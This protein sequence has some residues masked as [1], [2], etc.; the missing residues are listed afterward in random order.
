MHPQ[1]S[2]I[3][4]LPLMFAATLAWAAPAAQADTPA[5]APAMRERDVVHTPVPIVQPGRLELATPSGTVQVPI[6]V[7]RDWT[8]PQPGITRAV[9]VI[10]GW[11]RRDLTSGEYAAR[12]AGPSARD[13]LLITPQFLTAKDIAAHRLP[14][15]M[16]RWR[17]DDWPRARL[18][19]GPV[20][21]SSFEIVDEIF[22]RLAN[23][24]LF[25]N[26][27]MIVLAGHSAGGQYVQRYAALGR[28]EAD[29]G[30]API[31]LRYV[32]ANPATYLYFTDVRPGS[33]GA[34]APF[35]AK[36]CPRFE[37]WNY[38]LGS[39]VPPYAGAPATAEAVQARYLKR[40]VVYLLGTADNSP[41]EDAVGHNCEADAQG[42]TRYARGLA[43]DAYIHMLDPNTHQHVL[44]A[45]GIAHSS[46]RM[47]ASACGM[48]ALFD[49]PGCNEAVPERQ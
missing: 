26:L 32:V 30:S 7:S 18:S 35:D 21:I 45:P 44:E 13:A 14:D 17:E 36:Q 6:A 11:P 4:A 19:T 12:I 2:F 48:A 33:D 43:Y 46:G 40:D 41:D 38:G 5:A 8:Q 16:L 23:R 27:R 37:R 42:L 10:P 20:A 22:K 15:T 28:G 34:F 31:H 39:G 25:P 47:Y 29:L 1:R 49:K 3:R 24:T 9:I